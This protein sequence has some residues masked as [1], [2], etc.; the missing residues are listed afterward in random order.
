MAIYVW[1]E[2]VAAGWRPLTEAE[3]KVAE[4]Q[5][6]AALVLLGAL[7]PD[8]AAQS[9]DLVKLVIVKMV[10][11]VLKNPDGYRIRNAS[12][13]DYTEGGTIDSSLSTGELYV[14][15]EELKWLGAR[16]TGRAFEVRL[17]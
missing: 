17:G 8:L 11:R 1:P 4:D 16:G 15:P 5:I 10:R 12:I 3:S 14:S 7:V 13:D 9:E 2:D 6:G